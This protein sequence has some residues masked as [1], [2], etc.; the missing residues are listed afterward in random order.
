[1][2]D[3][4]DP[5]T[6]RTRTN[7]NEEENHIGKSVTGERAD[8][9]SIDPTVAL[10]VARR[11]MAHAKYRNGGKCRLSAKKI[12]AVIAK[13]RCQLTNVPFRLGKFKNCSTSPYMPSID[14]IDPKRS[15]TTANTQ[16]IL[17]AKNREKGDLQMVDYLELLD[18]IKTYSNKHESN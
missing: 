13:G 5:F 3:A 9:F 15:Y 4:S 12:A 17:W 16:I 11:I 10:H 18:E 6:T 14:K 8:D 7:V 1:M 2:G